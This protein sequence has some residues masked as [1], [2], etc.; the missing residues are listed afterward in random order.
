MVGH[1]IRAGGTKK[2][3]EEFRKLVPKPRKWLLICG[4]N[5]PDRISLIDLSLEG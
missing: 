4:D 1:F 3:F 5:G 2:H